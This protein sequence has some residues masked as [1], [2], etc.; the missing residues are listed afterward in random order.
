MANEAQ[1]FS[2]DKVKALKAYFL[3]MR[4]SYRGKPEFGD[5]D[6]CVKLC[7]QLIALMELAKGERI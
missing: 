6:I 2:A 7:E 5:L 1:H 4:N 3:R